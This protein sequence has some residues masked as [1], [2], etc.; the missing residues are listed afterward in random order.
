M[1]NPY[2][3]LEGKIELISNYVLDRRTLLFTE[4]A[5]KFRYIG[6]SS[7]PKIIAFNVEDKEELCVLKPVAD[8]GEFYELPEGFL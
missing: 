2:S 7:K 8:Q 4:F 5:P 6:P 3:K 1:Y